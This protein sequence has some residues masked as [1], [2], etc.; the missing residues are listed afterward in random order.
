MHTETNEYG[1]PLHACNGYRQ[2]EHYWKRLEHLR[3]EAEQKVCARCGKVHT[4]ESAILK[5]ALKL[6]VQRI[7]DQV[8]ADVIAAIKAKVSNG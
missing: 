2:D 6:G 7:S 8:D 1:V 5:A 4:P 3:L